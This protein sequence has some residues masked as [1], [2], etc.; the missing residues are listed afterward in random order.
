MILVMDNAPA[1]EATFGPLY[2]QARH[3][4]WKLLGDPTEAEDAAAEAMARALLA[5][6]KV[7]RLPY[8]EA[9]VMR[10]TANVAIDVLRRRPDM[11]KLGGESDPEAG[12]VDFGEGVALGVDIRRALLRLSRRQRQIVV[13]RWI[14]GLTEDEV[15]RGL[16]LSRSAVR[17]HAGRGLAAMR[18]QLGREVD[19]VAL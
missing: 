5:W 14:G 1:F 15:S 11:L 2:R 9:W 3:V 18:E 10:V 4:A 17:T 16:G 19:Y 13:L 7:G 6:R 12:P 8:R